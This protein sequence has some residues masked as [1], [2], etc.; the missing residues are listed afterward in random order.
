MKPRLALYSD[1]EIPAN[2]VVN[3][4]LL[5]LIGAAS[6]RIG[7]LSSAP[8]PERHY[9]SRKQAYY[10]DLG[11]DLSVYVD[12]DVVAQSGLLAALFDCDAIHL[13]GG[14]TYFFLRWL[15]VSGMIQSLR[16]F[17][18]DGGVLI[19][20]SAGSLLMTR[21]IAIAELSGDTPDPSM[22]SLEALGL[23]DFQFWPHYRPGA[24][25]QPRVSA[26]LSNVDLAYAC[27]DGAGVIVDGPRVEL[28]GE[29]KAFRYGQI[30]A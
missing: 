23:V 27:P 25:N 21:S 13:T 3:R 22:T 29:V 18:N 5:T 2:V 12:S 16:S 15:L 7:Y 19:G 1:Q 17:A 26:F 28:I 11:C 10:H 14:N 30:D 8:D 6:P 24:E 4:R 20:A 9:F